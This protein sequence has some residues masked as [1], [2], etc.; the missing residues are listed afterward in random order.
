M[1]QTASI[2]QTVGSLP[3]QEN[4]SH[5]EGTQRRDAPVAPVPAVGEASTLAPHLALRENHDRIEP[6]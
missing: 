4:L 1:Q 2:G 5:E 6:I 3:Q